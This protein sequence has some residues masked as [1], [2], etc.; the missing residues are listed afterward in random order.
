MNRI[1]FAAV[2]SVG[3]LSN[4]SCTMVASTPAQATDEASMTRLNNIYRNLRARTGG[5]LRCRDRASGQHLSQGESVTY[6][7]TLYANTNYF[8]YA[9][10]C[11]GVS[12]LDIRLYDENWNLIS[13]DTETDAVPMVAVTPKW[14]GTFYIRMIMYSGNGHANVATCWH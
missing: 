6:R 7:T 14:S 9:A 8:L 5:R 12:D 13:K 11:S 1:L 10:G 4:T 3:A 2:L